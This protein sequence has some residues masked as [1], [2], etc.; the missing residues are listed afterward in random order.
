MIIYGN[1]EPPSSP[2]LI[3][4]H[5]FGSIFMSR[6]TNITC[7]KKSVMRT[8][9]FPAIFEPVSLGLAILRAHKN[10]SNPF[11]KEKDV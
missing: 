2:S 10:P 9:G 4:F 11:K 7:K 6:G 5:G 8:L 1:V 3:N